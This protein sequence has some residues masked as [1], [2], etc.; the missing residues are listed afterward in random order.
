MWLRIR[1]EISRY[2]PYVGVWRGVW[3]PTETGEYLFKM[4]HH[5]RRKFFVIS[6]L[7]RCGRTFRWALFRTRKSTQTYPWRHTQGTVPAF[8]KFSGV[9]FRLPTSFSAFLLNIVY[10][11]QKLT[12]VHL[13]TKAFLFWFRWELST[14]NGRKK[15]IQSLPKSKHI[16]NHITLVR[17]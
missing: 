3:C 1:R 13:K 6:L 16:Q 8:L 12:K 10:F 7:R 5:G 17:D 11:V 14:Y 9:I 2:S 15:Y 4:L